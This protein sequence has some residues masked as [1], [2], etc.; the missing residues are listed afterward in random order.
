MEGRMTL[1]GKS[2]QPNYEVLNPRGL[3][4]D[5][6]KVPLSPRALDL[7]GRVI[8]VIDSG[9][10]GAHVFTAKVSQLLP[11][12]LPGVEVR[13]R[14]KPS[15]WMSSDPELWDE[16]AGSGSAFI[17]GPAGGTSGHV[18][19]ARWSILL[20]KKGVPGVYVLSEGYERCVQMACD[21]A[22]MPQLR[23]V[24]TP[25]PSW[26]QE[27]LHVQLDR[28]MR[29]IVEALTAPLSD[30]EQ[31]TEVIAREQPPRRAMSGTLSGVQR[32]F[33]EQQ[34]TDGLPIIPP[35]EEAVAGML[36]GTGHAPDAVVTEAMLPE[37]WRVTVEKV[38]INGVMAGCKPSDMP[39]LLAI[40]EAF[41][42]S[43][44][45]GM[46]VSANSFC[47]M[48]VVNGPIAREIGMNGEVNAL[49]PG[50][51]ANATIGRALRLFLT[52]LG[53]LTAGVNLMACQGNPANY[54]FAFTENAEASPWEPL[55]VSMGYGRGES[56]VTIFSGGWGHGGTRTGHGGAPLSLDGI[57]EVI[58]VFQSPWGAAVLLSPSLARAIAKEK[59]FTK[60]DLQKYLWE[61]TLK[62]IHEF[63]SNDHYTTSIERTLKGQEAGGMKGVWPEWYLHADPGKMVPVY[64]RSEFIVPIVVG[65]ENYDGFQGWKMDRPSSASIDRWR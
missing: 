47:F 22:G 54:S 62:T 44:F 42:K 65:G 20:E 64:G 46:S 5:I 4:P 49:G 24:V 39:V 23:R 35:T 11:Q 21:G 13:L 60:Q 28:I 1:A 53:G 12:Y 61:S 9:I 16:V 59:K 6:Y 51:Q 36:D 15:G 17:Y 25:M 57:I 30:D 8:F 34:W 45:E 3:I 18:W 10:Y 32:Y 41:S 19:G 56:V 37:R 7:K 26:G 2:V 50:N 14:S 48:T 58:R 27:S 33:Y 43:S 31:R 52:N 40:V 38:A 29:Q 63:R 55:H